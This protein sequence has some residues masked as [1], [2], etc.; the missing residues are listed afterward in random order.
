M[1]TPQDYQVAF[2]AARN[3]L[4][5]NEGFYAHMIPDSVVTAIAHTIVDSV[6]AERT[7]LANT[8]HKTVSPG[9]PYLA[10]DRAARLWL[11]TNESFYS[12]SI[13]DQ[14][15]SEIVKDI[16]NSVDAHRAAVAKPAPK[17]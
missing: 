8:K 1:S 7:V 12:G 14:Q 10:G 13:S 16:V 17:K 11:N 9:L 2:R 4:N 5:A 3:W 6:D 15:I